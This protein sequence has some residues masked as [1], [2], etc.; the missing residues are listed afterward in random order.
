MR[1]HAFVPVLEAVGEADITAHVDFS[2]LA[3]AARS[4]GAAAMPLMTQGDFLLALGILERAGR[5]GAGKDAATQEVIRAAVERLAGP[6]AMGTLFKVLLI[7][8]PGLVPPPHDPA[9]RI[10]PA[11]RIA[12]P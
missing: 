1:S 3:R 11:G 2:A 10:S 4:A 9:S 8:A 12:S 6:D 5:L 7:A